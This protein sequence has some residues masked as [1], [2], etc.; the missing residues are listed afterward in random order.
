MK[1]LFISSLMAV[2]CLCAEDLAPIEE[3]VVSL[4]ASFIESQIKDLSSIERLFCAAMG[5]FERFDEIES[6][7]L[8][9]V[10]ALQLE[11]DFQLLYGS[12]DKN[13]MLAK[14]CKLRLDFLRI[15][16]NSD[17]SFPESLAL[18]LISKTED[19]LRPFAI[20]TQSSGRALREEIAQNVLNSEECFY[21]FKEFICLMED[22]PLVALGI[23]PISDFKVHGAFL[24]EEG[25]PHI[26]VSY[27]YSRDGVIYRCE[28]GF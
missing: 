14:A 11:Q 23:T 21:A 15:I 8:L 25:E 1:I 6:L 10:A 13:S 18:D 7:D 26:L 2:S 16:I 28:C 27:Q 9:Q 5:N 4:E 12:S 17:P 22:D 19:I 3:D 24:S 20:T